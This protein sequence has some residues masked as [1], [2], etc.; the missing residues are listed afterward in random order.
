MGVF[1]ADPVSPQKE[2]KQ[3]LRGRNNV[4]TQH[5]G[6]RLEREGG[7]EGARRHTYRQADPQT[8]DRYTSYHQLPSRLQIGVLPLHFPL[9]WQMRFADPRSLF[10]EL[11]LYVVSF[12]TKYLRL[13]GRTMPFL[14]TVGSGH[15][16]TVKITN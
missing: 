3:S 10:P 8:T 12:V 1:K 16:T 14:I 7:R 2:S 4:Q 9:A 15:S 6:R 11:H 5:R 13:Y